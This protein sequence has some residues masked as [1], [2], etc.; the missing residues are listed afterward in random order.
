MTLYR[1]YLRDEAGMQIGWNP[2]QN[3]TDAGARKA[4][5]LILRER[6]QVHNMEV[7]RDAD[8]VFRLSRC[9]LSEA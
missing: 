2:I 9:D 7:W 6:P 8:L 1:C 5:L 4:A 3:D